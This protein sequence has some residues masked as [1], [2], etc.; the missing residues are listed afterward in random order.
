MH[1]T[2]AQKAAKNTFP[3]SPYKIFKNVSNGH[4]C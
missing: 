1:G 3:I 4:G 2:M